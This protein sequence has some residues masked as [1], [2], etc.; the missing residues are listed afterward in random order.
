M[1]LRT[2][3]LS[4]VR[5]LAITRFSTQLISWAS[6]IIV[7]RLLQPDDYGLMA[8]AGVF[9]ALCMLLQ[10]MGLG[11]AII[12]AKTM[13]DT[14]LKQVFGIVLLFNGF[15]FVVLLVVSPLIAEFF[16][17]PR[18]T[19]IIPVLAIQFLILAFGVI[20][21]ARLTRYMKFR[22]ISIVGVFSMISSTITTLFLAWLGYGVWALIIGSLA[23]IVIRIVGLNIVDPFFEWPSFNFSGFA[24]RAKFGSY[25]FL[26][27]ILWY[28]YSQADVFI[29]GKMLGKILLGNYSVAM[30]LATLPLSKIGGIVNMIGLPAYSKLQNDRKLAE[31]YALKILRVIAFVAFPVFFGISSVAPEIV[32]LLIGEKWISAILPLQILSLIIPLK[33]LSLSLGPAVNGLGRPDI[34]MRNMAVACIVMP[35]SF[36]IGVKWGLK[37]VSIAWV[38]SYSLWFLFM[39]SQSLPVIGLSM[40]SFFK[41]FRVPAFVATVMYFILYLTKLGLDKWQVNDVFTFGILII[42]GIAVYTIGM[43][44]FYR[45]LCLEIWDLRHS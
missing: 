22:A 1:E 44:L 40:R 8:M 41:A 34:N 38:I 12:Q 26:Q 2:E 19:N 16:K 3:V 7:M 31:K 13:T 17:E 28:A 35:V 43:L 9:I 18:L 36:I 27:G 20:P 29:V 33:S 30:H 32:L 5:W 15:L 37:G 45:D 24:D 39:L 42:T 25:T 23:G 11:A 6:T 4:G 21:N 10:E 14:L